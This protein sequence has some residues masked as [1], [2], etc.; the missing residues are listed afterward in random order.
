MQRRKFIASIGSVAAGA[1]AVTGTGAFT[2]VE[3]KR[4]VSVQVANDSE[5]YLS[6]TANDTP[7]GNEYAQTEGGT[8]TGSKITL[9]FD[10]VTKNGDASGLNDDATTVIRDVLTI[11]NQGTQ[12]VLVRISNLPDGMSAFADDFN[13]VNDQYEPFGKS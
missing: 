4:D 9:N 13:G 12:R 7:N 10:E 8:S 6:I 3:A 5:A 1:A 11:Q 2:S